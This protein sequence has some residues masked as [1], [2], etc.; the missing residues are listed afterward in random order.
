MVFEISIYARPRLLR[1]V[2]ILIENVIYS[3]PQIFAQRAC[4]GSNSKNWKLKAILYN[5]IE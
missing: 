5:D 3:D 1:T 2:I 4:E